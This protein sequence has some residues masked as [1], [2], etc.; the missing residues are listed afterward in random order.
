VLEPLR[1]A[2]PLI[3]VSDI[4]LQRLLITGAQL[5]TLNEYAQHAE[6]DVMDVMRQLEP[7]LDTNI[8]ELESV[9]H[10]LFL[11]TAP[12]GRPLPEGSPFLPANLWEQLRQVGDQDY[13]AMLWR[14]IRGL[15]QGGWS[16]RTH[17][18]RAVA[19]LTFLELHADGTWLPM[20][21]LPRR[22]RLSAAD[23][24]LSRA[25]GRKVSKVVVVCGPGHL[26]DA[27]TEIRVWMT[28]GKRHLTVLLLE[29]P[30]Y[31]PCVLSP[32]DTSVRPTSIARTLPKEN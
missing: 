19:P 11:H 14:I 27:V 21:V 5:A 2:V 9:G 30:R 17:P 23:G 25:E 15:E 20:I 1:Q 8:L 10:E 13:A 4:R 22:G 26:D 18:I 3:D 7:Y 29:Q 28:R 32:N 31:T 24:P 6:M 16:V 12:Q